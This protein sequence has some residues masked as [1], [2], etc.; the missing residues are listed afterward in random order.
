MHCIKAY[1]LIGRINLEKLSLIW[2]RYFLPFMDH[3][4]ELKALPDLCNSYVLE[5][6]A[7]VKIEYN[8]V[9]LKFQH[10]GT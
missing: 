5:G 6:P 3:A 7:L 8:H 1:Q 10:T 2:S 4:A 9:K